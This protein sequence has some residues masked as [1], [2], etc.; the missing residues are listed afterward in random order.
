MVGDDLL[1]VAVL[2]PRFGAHNG[3]RAA[4]A[5]VELV[6]AVV[7]SCNGGIAIR[8]DLEVADLVFFGEP[9]RDG[10]RRADNRLIQSVGGLPIVSA[11]K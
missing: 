5:V 10:K 9:G 6:V 3:A 7:V 2:V 8:P 1:R 11:S 4:L